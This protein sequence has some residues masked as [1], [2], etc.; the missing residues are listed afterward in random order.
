MIGALVLVS[1]DR[2]L[3]SITLERAGFNCLQTVPPS[4]EL[5][6]NDLAL[7]EY[8]V[9]IARRYA[10]TPSKH[11]VSLSKKVKPNTVIG[12]VLGCHT[13]VV[14]HPG[15]GSWNDKLLDCPVAKREMLSVGRGKMWVY[16]TGYYL[17]DLANDKGY[18]AYMKTA[19]QI[20]HIPDAHIE[21]LIHQSNSI[22]VLDLDGT[23]SRFICSTV[24]SFHNALGC[25]P[26]TVLQLLIEAGMSLDGI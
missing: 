26:Y 3:G 5:P 16:H 21:N 18:T 20:A 17:L 23:G 24:G 22:G 8:V 25:C 6:A 4:I 14:Y 13:A 11:I 12:G 2:R 19:I 10:A 1:P 7:D 9:E 15:K